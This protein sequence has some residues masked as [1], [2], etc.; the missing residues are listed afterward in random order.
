MSRR[1]CPSARLH[2]YEEDHRWHHGKHFKRERTRTSKFEELRYSRRE[3]ADLVRSRL[4]IVEDAMRLL[5]A[6]AEEESRIRALQ[7]LRIQA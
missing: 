6:G 7:V 3:C 5:E 2:L 1:L 4:R